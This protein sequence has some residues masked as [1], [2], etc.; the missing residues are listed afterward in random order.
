[1][2]EQGKSK[3]L[4]PR[5]SQD[6]PADH[7]LSPSKDGPKR[8]SVM[9][10]H[11]DNKLLAPINRHQR[12]INELNRVGNKSPLPVRPTELKPYFNQIRSVSC[13]R[14][15]LQGSKVNMGANQLLQMQNKMQ[16]NL[17]GEL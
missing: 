13:T 7:V 5:L 8:S 2:L 16:A 11:K 4:A 17:N 9:N 15:A 14:G 10:Y 1:M 3:L 6:N 12:L